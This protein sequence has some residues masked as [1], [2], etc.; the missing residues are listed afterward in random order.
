MS[1]KKS[2]RV[3]LAIGVWLVLSVV[4]FGSLIYVACTSNSVEIV[5]SQDGFSGDLG[6][7]DLMPAGV[8]NYGHRPI[9][10][11]F[12]Y[13]EGHYGSHTVILPF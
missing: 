9:S 7:M 11:T 5:A 3:A 6:G 13:I 8:T 12:S 4:V 1:S 10:L 2:G